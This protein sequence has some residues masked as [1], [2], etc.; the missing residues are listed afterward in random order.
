EARGPAARAA[1]RTSALTGSGEDV[2]APRQRAGT[3]QRKGP[4]VF[5][6]LKHGA[7]EKPANLRSPSD[8]AAL[9][10]CHCIFET[11][12]LGIENSNVLFLPRPLRRARLERGWSSIFSHLLSTGGRKG[13]VGTPNERARSNPLQ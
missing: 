7:N 3:T 9:K 12:Y 10:M 11:M 13:E 2:R 5:P 6:A 4:Y 1:E 8:N